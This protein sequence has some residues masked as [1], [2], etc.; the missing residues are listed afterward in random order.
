MER[1]RFALEN[2]GS[3]RLLTTYSHY[4]SMLSLWEYAMILKPFEKGRS[5]VIL[6]IPRN[7]EKAPLVLH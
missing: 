6:Y 5:G 2:L 4:L 3:R 1:T 7:W